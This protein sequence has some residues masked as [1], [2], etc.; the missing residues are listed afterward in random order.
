MISKYKALDA[1]LDYKIKMHKKLTTEEYGLNLKRYGITT[2]I[3]DDEYKGVNISIFHIC[4]IHNFRFKAQPSNVVHGYPCPL[5]NKEVVRLNNEKKYINTLLER[6]IPVVLDDD[7]ISQRDKVY[8]MC[9]ICNNRWKTSPRRIF[10]NDYPCPN[11]AK[12]EVAKSRMKT[13]EWYESEIAK[14]HNNTLQITSKYLG[15]KNYIDVHCNICGHDWNTMAGNLVSGHGCPNCRNIAISIRCKK[16]IEQYKT[17]VDNM[18]TDIY[19]ISE[20]YMDSST[21]ILHG[22]KKCGYNYMA[23]PSNVLNG[24]GKCPLCN[25]C[26]SLSKDE[27]MKCLTR[28]NKKLKILSDYVNLRT[29]ATFECEICSYIWDALPNSILTNVF[30]CPNCAIIERRKPIISNEDFIKRIY[31]VN[32]NIDLLSTY[33]GMGNPM[34][35]HC[36]ICNTFWTVKKAGKLMYNGCPTCASSQLERKTETYLQTLSIPYKKQYKRGDL[37][38]IGNGLLSY[39]FYLPNYNMLI[40]CQGMQHEKPVEHFGGQKTFIR[41]QIHDIRKRRYAKEHKIQFITIWYDQI[42]D[43]PEILNNY[44]NNLKL[45]CVTTTG[46]A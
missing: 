22:C 45:E 18:N 42:D 44:L 3:P 12:I 38:G 34:N 26:Y 4:L 32:P 15:M 39:D 24:F 30:N 19:V 11:C 1:N 46:V 20:E 13:Q 40:E 14:K 36:K 37:I 29:K 41:Q 10:A 28:K 2:T 16:A 6:N 43:I 9:L 7:Y 31:S 17:E 33:N 27:F 23:T 8:H 21:P 5:C 25:K 35:C